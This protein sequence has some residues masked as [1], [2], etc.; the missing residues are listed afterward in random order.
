M[1]LKNIANNIQPLQSG[2]TAGVQLP[3]QP[4]LGGG[5]VGD[6]AE[7]LQSKAQP[8]VAT[9]LKSD[10]AQS[11]KFSNHAVDR[12]RM[13]G[14]K[15]GPEELARLNNAV[16]KATAKG[17]RDTLVLMG[18]SAMIVNIKSKTVVTAMDAKALKENVFT[19][20]DSTVVA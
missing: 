7:I 14:I 11:L 3:K 8:K 1:E 10:A 17:A 9:E 5:K 19:N 6:F 18:D 12:I 13:R 4:D 15:M 20:I 16:E 2:A